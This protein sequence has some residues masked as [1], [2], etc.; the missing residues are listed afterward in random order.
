MKII[1]LLL[2]WTIGDRQRESAIKKRSRNLSPFYLAWL[3]NGPLS[4]MREHLIRRN[5]DHTHITMFKL[6]IE[7]LTRIY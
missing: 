1:L 2:L 6:N 5:D 3:G 4:T 7:K